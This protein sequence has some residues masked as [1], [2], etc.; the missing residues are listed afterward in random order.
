MENS[1]AMKKLFFVL[2][3]LLSLT[4]AHGQEA[5]G[6]KAELKSPE[7]NSDGTIT[8]RLFAPKAEKVEAVIS[9]V[10]TPEVVTM[11]KNNDGI[12]EGKT[13][14]LASDLYTYTFY[15]DGVKTDDP[16][17]VYQLRD[18]ATVQN[19]VI[20]PG[21]E[22]GH[23]YS[24]NDV[25][26]GDVTKKWYHSTALGKDRR[27][28]IYTPPSYDPRGSR[29]YPVLYLLHGM[30]GDENAWSELGRAAQILDNLIAEGKIEEMI[31]VMPNGNVAMQAAPGENPDGMVQPNFN[32]PRTMNGEFESAFAEIVEWTD[33]NYLTK[34]E[35]SSR[36]I[37]G[38][39]MGGF[40]SMLISMNNP[41]MFGYVGLFS[42]ATPDR[43][44]YDCDTYKN[45]E[46]KLAAQASASPSLYWI[47]IGKDDFLYDSNKTLREMLDK[48]SMKY[49]Y[50]E[51]D[52]GHIWR[53]WRDYLVLFTPQLFK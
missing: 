24:V 22:K 42:S 9:T 15:V 18:V 17:N 30:G 26:H 49:T 45:V 5:L 13:P 28:T 44:K 52:G 10:P 29:R 1:F 51:S 48:A 14:A 6:T 3:G 25:K 39:S 36:A 19:L 11:T 46:S 41:E 33:N 27:L 20:V 32:L 7:I 35:K 47:G 53:N 31:V 2:L 40:H 12:W 16:S 43:A 21:G 37:A 34:A 8:L 4:F 23:L 38:L 50:H